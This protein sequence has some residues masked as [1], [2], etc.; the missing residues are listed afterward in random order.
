MNN[1][2]LKLWKTLTQLMAWNDYLSNKNLYKVK[3]LF[4]TMAIRKWTF[5]SSTLVS[6]MDPFYIRVG[7]HLQLS[8]VYFQS[9]ILFVFHFKGICFRFFPCKRCNQFIG[10]K[11][12]KAQIKP[13]RSFHKAFKSIGN[14][15]IVIIQYT[16]WFGNHAWSHG[17]STIQQ[18]R[19]IGNVKQSALHFCFIFMVSIA[20]IRIYRCMFLF[21]HWFLLILCIMNVLISFAYN[22]WLICWA[23]L[24]RLC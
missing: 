7:T 3:S 19:F 12:L 23:F 10:L 16:S 14:W 8:L 24:L 22:C 11:K 18:N 5:Y 9:S 15:F 20:I 1:E 17:Y 2:N 6:Q 4:F 13:Q 21:I